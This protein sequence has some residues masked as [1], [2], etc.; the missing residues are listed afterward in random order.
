[1]KKKKSIA[2]LTI[3]SILIILGSVF[4]FVSCEIGLYNYT[5]FPKNISLGLD[6]SGGAYAVY[7]VVN[8]EDMSETDFNNAL[9]GTRSSLESL[10]VSKGYTE[11]Q[12]TTSNNRIRV[13]V[14]D[15]DDPDRIFDL[16]GRPASLEFKA[17]SNNTGTS[18]DPPI[19]GDDIREAGVTYNNE[20]GYYEVALRFTDAGAE[21]FS[22]ATSSAASN[23]GQIGIYINEELVIAP[24]VPAAITGGSVSISGQYT[25]DQAYELAV[26]I[27]A[28][29]FPLDLRV[30]ESNTLTATLGENAISAGVI[31]GLV[32]LALIIIYLCSL[33]RLMGLAAS[34]SLIYYTI[35]YV[36]FL[37]IFPFVQLTLAGVAGVLLSIGMA[38]DANVIIFER[39]KEEYANGKTLN[40]SVKTGFKRSLGAILDGNITTLIG[41]I[42]MSFVGSASIK[43]FGITL[44]IG[45]LISLFTS[46]VVSRFVLKSFLAFSKESDAIKYG[47][48][49]ETFVEEDDGVG[50]DL[51]E[52]AESPR[53][54]AGKKQSKKSQMEG[55]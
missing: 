36:F 54:V 29:T 52:V 53:K 28:G 31:A 8:A 12:V 19:T 46:L 50:T 7:D 13:E 47:L 17:Y 45:I 33:Y 42:V 25:Y 49:R 35:T 10:L 39:I 6:L 11:A 9:E 3:L 20:K 34:L 21:K 1:M 30:I 27:Q 40:T 37:S 4:A 24:T 41:A 32:G 23:Q 5:A 26:K 43:G 51:E 18:Y 2:I 55:I 44:V 16:I 22:N 38:V 48:K 15:V 14:P